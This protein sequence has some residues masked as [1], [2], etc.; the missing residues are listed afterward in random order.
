MIFR[1]LLYITYLYHPLTAKASEAQHIEGLKS[2]ANA[3]M[4]KPF[5]VPVLKQTIETL[6]YNYKS[7]VAGRIITRPFSSL[8]FVP[9]YRVA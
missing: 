8:S 7:V 2:N 9:Y 6:L 1:Q 5:N 4:A 3:Y